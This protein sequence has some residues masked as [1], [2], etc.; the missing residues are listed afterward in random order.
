M[1]LYSPQY[2]QS[3]IGTVLLESHYHQ[4][5]LA[6]IMPAVSL[7]PY[8]S[9]AYNHLSFMYSTSQCVMFK[10]LTDIYVYYVF[11]PYAFFYISSVYI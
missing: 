7:L 5:I 4:N 2:S 1:L 9:C 3:L 10:I 11:Y 6:Q 8:L